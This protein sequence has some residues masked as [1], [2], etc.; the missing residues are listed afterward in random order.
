MSFQALHHLVA[1][2]FIPKAD[3]RKGRAEEH[4]HVSCYAS[5]LCKGLEENTNE[6][7]LADRF[8]EHAKG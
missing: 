6:I 3:T 5:I 1:P 8:T 2:A 7:S 4:T